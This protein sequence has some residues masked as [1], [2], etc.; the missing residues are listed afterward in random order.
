[1]D[2]FKILNLNR[3]PFSNSPEPDFFFP[4]TRHIA[5]LQQLELAIRLRRG[6]NVVM[7][8]VGTGKTTLCRQLILRF[9]ET[10]EDRAGVETHLLLDPS[11]SAPI[12]FLNTV[13]M[14]FGLPG[15]DAGRS[16]WQIKEGIKNS[17][18]QKG[19]DENR[20]VVLIIDEGQKLPEFCREILREFLNYET[21]EYKLL[22]I[23]IFAQN[24]FREILQGHKN[25]ADRVNQYYDLRPL[26]FGEAREMIRFRLA[27]AG[28]GAEKPFLFSLPGMWA[29]YRATGGYPRKIVTLCHQVLLSLIIQNRVKAGWGIVR[30]NVGRLMPEMI[31]K[32]RWAAAGSLAVL[33][34]LVAGFLWVPPGA[35]DALKA[36][37]LEK[38]SVLESAV[39]EKRQAAPLAVAEKP[40][41]TAVTASARKPELTPKPAET[42]AVPAAQAMAVLAPAEKA[43][44]GAGGAAPPEKTEAARGAA[45]SPVSGTPATAAKASAAPAAKNAEV[46]AQAAA[47]PAAV[48][49]EAAVKAPAAPIPVKAEVVPAGPAPATPPKAASAGIAGIAPP[50]KLGQLQIRRGGTVLGLL[51]EIYGTTETERF[52]AVIRAN[53]HIKDM[54]WVIAGETIH[55][56]A[57][58]GKSDPLEPGKI[59]VRVAREKSLAEAYRVFKD[60]P[61]GA[62]PIRLIPAWNPG[63]GLS[64]TIV[65]RQGFENAEAAGR[66]IRN[67]PF[68]L[69]GSA[70]IL[71]KPGGNT[72]YFYR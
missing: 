64:F 34:L 51:Q 18:F 35:G 22:Q 54:N 23:V 49:P 46:A 21:N 71:E 8:E 1:M 32:E 16:E 17:L 68:V 61:D 72:V 52:R 28:R 24:E 58:R 40:A 9:T 65:L 37:F 30:S 38:W 13:A 42:A 48:K 41:S 20:T 11:F 10:E 69:A 62:P 47:A 33:L 14:S 66:A 53:P 50:E 63:E 19:V 5:C 15:A 36:A 39:S 6:L 12:E 44:A 60:Y 67:L 2:Y 57:I 43:A 3:E 59:W 7:G 70:G 26:N 4:S 29:V 45:G 55:F 31:R 56:P 27:R 25:F